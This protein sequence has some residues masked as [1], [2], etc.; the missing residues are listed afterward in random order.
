MD[1]ILTIQNITIFV[2][3]IFVGFHVVWNVTP[4]LHTPLMSVTNAISGIVIVGAILQV[5]E[6]DGNIFSLSSILG[7]IAIFF[8]S[9]N[10]FGGFMVTQRMLDMFKKKEK[11]K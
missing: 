8:A 7:A 3:A 2:L 1:E 9:I 10:I 6:I 4:A 5:V 11:N